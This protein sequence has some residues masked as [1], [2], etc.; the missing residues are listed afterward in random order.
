[1]HAKIDILASDQAIQHYFNCIRTRRGN[2]GFL[3]LGTKMRV[4]S[5]IYNFVNYTDLP[6]TNTTISDLIKFKRTNPNSNDIEQVV[7]RFSTELPIQNHASQASCILG[8]FRAN[9]APLQLRVN[10]HFPPAEENCSEGTFLEIYHAQ[11]QETKDMIQWQQY[12]PERATASYLVPFEDIDL[13]RKDYA[14]IWIQA[15]RS[16]SRTKHPCFVPIQFAKKV[17]ESAKSSGRNCPFPNYAS[18][19]KKV[20]TF[21]REEY[22]VK[23]ISHY[24]RKRYVDI[25]DSTTIPKSQAAFLMG[26]K[27]KIA[28]EGIH[29]DLIYGRGLRFIEEL[30]K[31]YTDSGLADALTIDKPTTPQRTNTDKLD[32][33]KA[34]IKQ[35]QETIQ[36]LSQRITIPNTR[37]EEQ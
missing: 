33:L 23:L 1:M 29:L 35:Q 20:S 27:T 37:T 21:A 8:I 25:A 2:N 32:E 3:P 31:N 24:I 17:I 34:I 5:S 30:I 18:L 11:D 7:Q 10:T 16:K 12:V 15:I 19:W 13:S 6:I 36:A 28:K 26:D 9:F 4:R 14:I 22:K